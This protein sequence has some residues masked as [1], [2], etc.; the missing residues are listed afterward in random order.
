LAKA[1]SKARKKAICKRQS[2]LEREE[3]NLE[4]RLVFGSVA[5]KKKKDTFLLKNITRRNVWMETNFLYNQIKAF[6]PDEFFHAPGKYALQWQPRGSLFRLVIPLDDPQIQENAV[7]IMST[8]S[9]W[10]RS[11]ILFFF[12][13]LDPGMDL[14]A[15][16]VHP[17]SLVSY[18]T[19]N[20]VLKKLCD[21]FL[22]DKISVEEIQAVL[23]CD[24]YVWSATL[25]NL[26]PADEQVY[27]QYL[28][29]QKPLDDTKKSLAKS[30]IDGD[31]TL[32][33]FEDAKF[34]ERKKLRD[35][36][37]ME[38]PLPFDMETCSICTKLK[39]GLVSCH[40]CSNMVCE[41]C[42]TS[43]FSGKNGRKSISFLL[44]HQKYCMKLGELAP[45]L[46]AVEDEP[47]YLRE[48]R[49]T[50]RNVA[51]ELLL[52]KKE[53]D[54]MKEDHISEDE[55]EVEARRR[56]EEE[57]LRRAA[58]EAENLLKNNPK[59]LQKIREQFD[60][61]CRKFDRISRDLVDYT[62]KVLDKSHTEQFIARNTRLRMET[63]DR[64]RSMVV[65]P[66]QRLDL[67]ARALNLTGE[68]ISD[69][70]NEITSILDRCELMSTEDPGDAV[71]ELRSVSQRGSSAAT[72]QR[73][74]ATSTAT[75]TGTRTATRESFD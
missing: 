63:I 7:L 48:F 45:V 50:T 65:E 67:Q 60:S 13:P 54:L 5:P 17:A 29:E 46:P 61:R 43:I 69:L 35:I 58:E 27:H 47:A 22:L 75:G 14:F 8:F 40:T 19:K 1:K 56:A 10:E 70:L 55:E 62:E 28:N 23:M 3:I 34:P 24:Q 52:P 71:I 30:Y 32:E 51:L 68:F 25:Y 15:P 36:E 11:R 42:M 59:S 31:I 20:E 6:K 49:G 2:T 16:Q 9:K 41:A 74:S 64:L 12:G 37:A 26:L 57:R 44:M 39:A 21:L 66:V 53:S 4:W 72:A 38:Y 18:H 73:P 33:A